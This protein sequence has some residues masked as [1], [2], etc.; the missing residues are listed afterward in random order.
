MR[1]T[2][3]EKLQRPLLAASSFPRPEALSARLPEPYTRGRPP[4]G[5]CPG[6]YAGHLG[7]MTAPSPYRTRRG[8]AAGDPKLARPRSCGAVRCSVRFPFSPDRGC[9]VQAGGV[10]APEK[11]TPST[12]WRVI[13]F[14]H[15]SSCI[16]WKLEFRQ[17]SFHHAHLVLIHS[18]LCDCPA[19]NLF[20]TCYGPVF[21]SE[22][23]PG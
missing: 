11:A 19:A 8:P 17:F 22:F 9:S 21:L 15:G 20:P 4:V 18:L 2:G 6:H 3:P 10:S 12:A 23:Q 16:N 1:R 14:R 5:G 13:R 7:I